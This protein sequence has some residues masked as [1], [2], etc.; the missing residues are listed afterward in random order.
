MHYDLAAPVACPAIY[1]V[2][3]VSALF[4]PA[5]GANVTAVVVVDWV[6]DWQPSGQVQLAEKTLTVSYQ[7]ADIDR[8]VKRG[9]T[10]TVGTKVY[11]VLSM[12]DYPDAWTEYEGKAAVVE[13]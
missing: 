13:Q 4:T 6:A 9:E 3:G 12:A 11:R 2:F 10:F 1:S 7:R 8:K 5:T